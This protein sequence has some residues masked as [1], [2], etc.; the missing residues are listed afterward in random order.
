MESERLI[1]QP[2]DTDD[3]RRRDVKCFEKPTP[4]RDQLTVTGEHHCLRRVRW[5]VH[6]DLPSAVVIERLGNEVS[7]DWMVESLVIHSRYPI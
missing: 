4:A 7:G 3:H 6:R 2:V 5:D 1:G